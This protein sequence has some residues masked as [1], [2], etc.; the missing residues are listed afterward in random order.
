[1]SEKT[2]L[3]EFPCLY[4][5]KVIGN[6][7]ANLRERVVEIMRLHA[8]E[9]D[10]T[11]ITERASSEGRFVSVTVTIT[12]TGKPQLDNIFTDLKATGI[13]KMVL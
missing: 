6:G 2:P 13:V 1:M 9:F 12:A 4:P 7:D 8:G 5:I 10:E 11:A 3:L